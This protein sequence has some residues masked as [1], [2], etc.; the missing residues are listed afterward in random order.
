[1]TPEEEH[2]FTGMTPEEL[3]AYAEAHERGRQQAYAEAHRR[4]D[5]ITR[6]SDALRERNCPHAIRAANRLTLEAFDLSAD[7]IERIIM[8]CLNP[9]RRREEDA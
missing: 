2:R 9:I 7:E 6:L 8:A 5:A 4:S 1:M 3:A